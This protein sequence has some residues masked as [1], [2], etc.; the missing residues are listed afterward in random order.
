MIG[1]API[2]DNAPRI[3]RLA[4]GVS[5][6]G[7]DVWIQLQDRWGDRDRSPFASETEKQVT[8]F[9]GTGQAGQA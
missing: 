1:A 7:E 8:V 6:D 3:H 9:V 5:L 2:S 4:L